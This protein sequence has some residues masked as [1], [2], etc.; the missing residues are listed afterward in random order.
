MGFVEEMVG[1]LG[2]AGVDY[3]VVVVGGVSAVLQ[4][5]PI[6]TSDLDICAHLRPV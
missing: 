3:V 1:R 5:V 2:T 4:G 6:I